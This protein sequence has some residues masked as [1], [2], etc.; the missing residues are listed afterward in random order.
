M[1]LSQAKVNGKEAPASLGQLAARTLQR[2]Y[3][4]IE[5]EIREKLSLSLKSKHMPWRKTHLCDKSC[6]CHDDIAK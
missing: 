1:G 2:N 4:S 6:I 5:T 3:G